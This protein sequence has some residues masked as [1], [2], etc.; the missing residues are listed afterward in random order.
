MKD[1]DAVKNTDFKDGLDK[2]VDRLEAVVLRN[3]AGVDPQQ[4]E[5]TLQTLQGMVKDGLVLEA[6]HFESLGQRFEEVI[7]SHA[8]TFEWMFDNPDSVRSKEPT[9]AISFPEWLRRGSDIF[10]ITGKPGSGK[11]SLMKFLY[12]HSETK[13]LLQEWASGKKLLF[14]KFIFWRICA[15]RGQKSLDGLVRSLIYEVL[16]TT[17][18]LAKLLLPNAWDRA[19]RQLSGPGK[20]L[21]LGKKEI[22]DAFDRLVQLRGSAG[23]ANPLIKFR[24]CFFIDGLDEY[25]DSG[26]N[27]S[28]GALLNRL[29]D[30]V[31]GPDKNVKLCVSSRVQAPFTDRLPETQRM[32]L[33]HL[34]HGD[35]RLLVS[36]RLEAQ[37]AFRELQIKDSDGCKN[38]MDRIT[39]QADG[40]FLWVALLLNSLCRGLEKHDSLHMLQKRLESTPKEL[41][42]FL[43]QLLSSI[44]EPYRRGALLLFGVVLRLAGVQ[45]SDE[46]RN[47]R[48]RPT[49][50]MKLLSAFAVL[51]FAQEGRPYDGTFQLSDL[52]LGVEGSAASD[53]LD[54]LRLRMENVITTQTSSLLEILEYKAFDHTSFYL[55]FMHRSIPEVLQTCLVREAASKGID[56]DDTTCAL[57]W[58]FFVDAR[59]AEAVRNP[60][61]V[62]FAAPLLHVMGLPVRWLLDSAPADNS[63]RVSLI[64]QTIRV[65]LLASM[66]LVR[67]MDSTKPKHGDIFRLLIDSDTAH[68]KTQTGMDAIVD[69]TRLRVP[70][71][72][73]N[74]CAFYGQLEFVRWVS[75]NTL[76]LADKNRL[77]RFSIGLREAAMNDNLNP[78]HIKIVELLFE[79][80]LNPN[81][82]VPNS[83]QYLLRLKP[84]LTVVRGAFARGTR[85]HWDMVEKWLQHGAN[86]HLLV[87]FGTRRFKELESPGEKGN[88]LEILDNT[89]DRFGPPRPGYRDK[90]NKL[91]KFELTLRE[92]VETFHPHNEPELLA[93][94][95][96]YATRAG[97]HG[98]SGQSLPEATT[99]ENALVSKLPSPP[100]EKTSAPAEVAADR[101]N[102]G[103]PFQGNGDLAPRQIPAITLFFICKSNKASWCRFQLQVMANR[104]PV[105][106]LVGLTGLLTATYGRHD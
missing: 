25:D 22:F 72:L 24:I 62:P 13:Q 8:G 75:D 97:T 44:E 19:S 15:T 73:L 2:L 94:I 30:W 57:A 4:A 78:D 29:K 7:D 101:L 36:Q 104:E 88:A 82:E 48:H 58:T 83:T 12:T 76:V 103:Q 95:D 70:D 91:G 39:T 37:P 47:W 14:A 20:L 35:I 64:G 86:P 33:H 69:H 81:D 80:G 54:S 66:S 79:H 11:S 55:K 71:D 9:L 93:L 99:P 28:H 87:L 43:T 16:C 51:R 106:I 45:I 63:S 84:W 50:Y 59:C 21:H 61:E 68:Q 31:S 92:M 40:V 34:T 85:E 65:G 17:P 67:N 3:A 18:S 26:L 56:D 32:T 41:D 90:L 42:D 77:A 38:L 60:K 5:T 100:E 96:G 49:G 74:Y 53:N 27:E 23:P 89:N 102:D 6:L 52:D 105:A 1:M 10:H 46:N 98:S